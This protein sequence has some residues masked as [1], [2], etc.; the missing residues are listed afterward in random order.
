MRK[1][2]VGVR[3]AVSHFP[4]VPQVGRNAK[5]T[6]ERKRNWQAKR[7]D[8]EGTNVGF[9]TKSP[10]LSGVTYVLCFVGFWLLVNCVSKPSPVET[11][12]THTNRGH[13]KPLTSLAGRWEI[14]GQGDYAYVYKGATQKLY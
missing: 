13:I 5:P 8:M 9:P 14:V 6:R 1:G 12:A 4:T 7:R 10:I 11:K 3:P 2:I